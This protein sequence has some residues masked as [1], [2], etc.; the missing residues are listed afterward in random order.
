[1]NTPL[2]A[3]PSPPEAD[4]TPAPAA[5]IDACGLTCGGLEPLIAKHIRAVAPGEVIEIRSDRG[6]AA[7][8]I[9]AWVGLT[10]HTLVTVESDQPS[11]V[12]RYFVRKKT[13][14]T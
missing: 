11:R 2:D 1:M 10:G 4:R 9:R 8:G 7:E 6:E 3:P 5:T 13:P 12:A 14:Q